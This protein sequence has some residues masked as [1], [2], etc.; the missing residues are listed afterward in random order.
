MAPLASRRRV[1]LAFRSLVPQVP[2]RAFQWPGLLGFPQV[3]PPEELQRASPR[4]SERPQLELR[5]P[6]A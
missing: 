4:F 2:Q 5:L 1:Q 3:F 6:R